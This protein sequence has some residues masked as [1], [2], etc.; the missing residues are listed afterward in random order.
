M[1]RFVDIVVVVVVDCRRSRHEWF[2]QMV[3]I[4][5]AVFVVDKPI[6][7]LLLFASH[8]GITQFLI[9]SFKIGNPT[10][11]TH[12]VSPFGLFFKAMYGCRDRAADNFAIPAQP[13]FTVD[14]LLL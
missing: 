2:I 14:C 13:Q 4:P 6:F 10:P 8:G 1:F 11:N 3:I 12:C 7:L 5:T 9:A